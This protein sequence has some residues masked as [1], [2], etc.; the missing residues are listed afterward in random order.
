[1]ALLG[2]LAQGVQE[3]LLSR[4]NRLQRLTQVGVVLG[5]G[6]NTDHET[7][8]CRVIFAE[9]EHRIKNR[10][11]AREKRVV[12]GHDRFEPVVDLVLHVDEHRHE[13]FDLAREVVVNRRR[14]DAGRVGNLT[15]GRV[16]IA[17]RGER[18]AR[19]VKN[20]TP[21]FDS[22]ALARTTDSTHHGHDARRG[23]STRASR[24]FAQDRR[25]FER[26]ITLHAVTSAIDYVHRCI[27]TTSTQFSD[28][29]I[30]YDW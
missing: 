26:P 30:V 21:R 24:G 5:F 3:V 23:C 29:G 9:L 19:P 14:R 2:L 22:I 20:A 8:E 7:G 28:V 12:F 17:A 6:H 15:I 11:K 16:V 25:Q 27:C 10:I 1:M 13:Q 18:F 4:R